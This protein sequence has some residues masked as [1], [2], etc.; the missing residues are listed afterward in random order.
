MIPNTLQPV[1]AREGR[2]K[3]LPAHP[4]EDSRISVIIEQIEHYFHLITE[5]LSGIPSHFVF[6]MGE[7]SH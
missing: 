4:M 6:N 1:L 7:M 3:P 5:T 2:I